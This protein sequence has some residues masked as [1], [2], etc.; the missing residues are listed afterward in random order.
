MRNVT[1][2]PTAAE[3]APRFPSNRAH[4]LKHLWRLCLSVGLL[5]CFASLAFG[6]GQKPA[7]HPS[8]V[9]AKPRPGVRSVRGD[10]LQAVHDRLGS[11]VRREHP[12]LGGVQVIE[13]PANVP[14]EEALAHYRSSGLFEYVEPDQVVQVSATP[15]DPS[16]LDGAL[17]GMQKI[18]APAAWDIQN[19]AEDVIV[20]VIDTGIR[21]SHEDLASNM[22]RNP[23]ETGLD[24]NGNDKATKGIDDDGDGYVDDV[25]GINAIT[26]SGDPNDDF[27]HGT[28]CAGTI[29]GVGNN[30]TGVV[31]VA[32]RAKLMACK[33]LGSE[34]WGFTSDAI[35]CI[36]YARKKG[37]RIMS[38]SWGGGGYDPALVDAI[39]AARD[40]GII[41][42]AAAGNS[43]SDNDIY[44]F[45][46]A[47]YDL[48]NIVSVAAT[49]FYDGLAYFSCFGRTS[50]D[51]GAPG[52]EIYSCLNSSDS[53]YGYLSG[54]S[55]AT[56]HVAGALALLKAHLPNLSYT[57]L[58]RRVFETVDPLPA[59]SDKCVTGG[60]LNLEKMLT[61]SAP[62]GL[63]PGSAA[64]DGSVIVQSTPIELSWNA[65]SGADRY[66]VLSYYWDWAGW[67]WV[68][69]SNF[70]TPSNSA[71][72]W[73]PVNQTYYIW[74]VRA[75][76]PSSRGEW[77]DWAYFYLDA[78]CTCT[79]SASSQIIPAAGGTGTISVTAMQGC[80][81]TAESDDHWITITS[82]SSGDGTGTVQY[83]VAAHPARKARTG[84][85]TIG[86][87]T[88]T[89]TQAPK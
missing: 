6:E 19:N 43:A 69:D 46:P 51:L 33:F 41:F 12:D 1:K 7:H 74:M 49:D 65:S 2:I 48:D 36:D 62:T 37:A 26:G 66:E 21:Y 58:I 10:E 40:A 71:S 13:L 70:L 50:V 59:L 63:S 22:W 83:S 73:P 56:P 68:F 79:L 78:P 57:Q 85:L 72:C 28:H 24:A 81:W 55:M 34:G 35:A 16:F 30:A 53:A 15:N 76:N 5:L 39:A 89:V 75:G 17:W 77:S 8:R 11:R 38:N 84:T 82:G 32:W 64:P 27:F 42:V 52:V 20:A 4:P 9:L 31:G 61:L 29:G 87:Q 88:F 18:N 23:G 3:S 67:D 14:L 60:R 45:Y 47:S 44:P 86:G 80:D 54:T 25:Y